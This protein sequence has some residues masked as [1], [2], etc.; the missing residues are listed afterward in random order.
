[1]KSMKLALNKR[2]LEF[3]TAL[4][5]VGWGLWVFFPWW[6]TFQVSGA[7]KLMLSLTSEWVWGLSVLLIGAFQMVV[8]FTNKLKTRLF[9]TLLSLFTTVSLMMLYAFG[10]FRST[11]VI[12]ML[13]FSICSWMAY[14]EILADI[15]E[16]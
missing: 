7:Y 3:V 14:I 8:L 6:N 5:L 12:N 15:K 9:A 11:G 16:K 10:D 1:M 4:F 13:V 2:Q